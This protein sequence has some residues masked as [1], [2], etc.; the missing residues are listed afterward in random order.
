MSVRKIIKKG[1]YFFLQN[2]LPKALYTHVP[3][4]LDL[5]LDLKKL[6]EAYHPKVIFDVGANSGQTA[7]KLNSWFPNA[8]IHSFEPVS[9]TYKKLLANTKGIK[10][11]EAHAFALA[12]EAGTAK[13]FV[14]TDDTMSSL[15]FHE[16]DKDMIEREETITLSTIDLTVEKLGIN[17]IDLLKIDTE[18][19]DLEVLKGASK[20]LQAGRIKFLQVEAG[21]NPLNDRHVPLEA[22]MEFLKP[23]GFMPFGLYD[24]RL[25][26]SGKK[27]LRFVNPVYVSAQISA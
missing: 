11:I 10:N 2:L 27:R 18:G 21:M 15:Q 19:Y 13:I 5:C 4:G 8:Q 26:W 9:A 17:S 6:D 25:E 20:S 14:L 24:Q 1:A 23:Y 16:S 22:F 12:G 7:L 3:Q